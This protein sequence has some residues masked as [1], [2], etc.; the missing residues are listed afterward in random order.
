ML[1]S[2]KFTILR[3][4]YVSLSSNE[5]PDKELEVTDNCHLANR[6]VML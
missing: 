6:T 1:P 3:D 5:L 4:A 2:K